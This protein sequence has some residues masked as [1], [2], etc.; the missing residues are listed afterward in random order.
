[1]HDKIELLNENVSLLKTLYSVKQTNVRKDNG[2]QKKINEEAIS[3]KENTEFWDDMIEKPSNKFA[4]NNQLL[5]SNKPRNINAKSN[6]AAVA[7]TSVTIVD[8]HEKE[9]HAKLEHGQKT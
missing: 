5:Q 4:Y 8:K 1:M 7:G 3:T 6:Y 2:Y 9:S